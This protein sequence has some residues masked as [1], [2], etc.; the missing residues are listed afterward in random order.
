MQKDEDKLY[1][2]KTECKQQQQLQ[3]YYS[4]NP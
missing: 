2:I 1:L 3:S 4:N